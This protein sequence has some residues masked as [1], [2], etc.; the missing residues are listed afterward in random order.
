MLVHGISI[1]RYLPMPNQHY[2]ALATILALTLPLSIEA[3][4]WSVEPKISLRTGYNDNIRLT[5][6]PHDS[7]WETA[8]T[9]SVK[10]AM[11]EEN[12]GLSGDA[13]ISVRRFSG[14]SGRESSDT[15]DREDYH[16]GTDG[17]YNTLRNS[18]R[19]SLDYTRDSTLDSELDQTGNVVDDRATRERLFLAPAWT[20]SLTELINL[21]LAY[22]FTNV[23]YSDDPGIQD[24]VSYDYH[25]PSAALLYQFSPRTQATLSAGYSSYR[26]DA[27]VSVDSDTL[28]LQAGLS[29]N[30]SETLQASFLVGRRDTTSD[31]IGGGETDTNSAV[32]SASLTKTLETGSLSASLTRSSSPGADG[33]LFDRTRLVLLG[34][35]RFTETINSSLRIVYTENETIVNRLG[36][37]PNSDTEDFFRVTPRIEW[38]WSRAW[39][40]AGEYQYA[41]DDKADGSDAERNAVYVTLSYRPV[42]WSVAR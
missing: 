9:P 21:E 8:L 24:L 29:R 6:A 39:S 27:D 16:L 17:W 32:Y 11:A 28:S 41:T 26:P 34:K 12:K 33:E 4:E 30:F 35:H 14:G 38:R 5:A 1:N 2:I 22:E 15:L 10:F 7:V 23:D 25:T 18:F 19:A 42:K 40:L 13:R 31:I 20:T 3:A 36:I 37:T